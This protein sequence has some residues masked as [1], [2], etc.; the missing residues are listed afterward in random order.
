MASLLLYKSKSD[1]QNR[2]EK[3]DRPEQP[4]AT[5]TGTGLFTVVSFYFLALLYFRYDVITVE[6]LHITVSRQYVD[7]FHSDI[8]NLWKKSLDSEM[9]KHLQGMDGLI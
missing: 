6:F 4:F 2:E 7:V 9:W 1:T 8:D 3:A 5:K